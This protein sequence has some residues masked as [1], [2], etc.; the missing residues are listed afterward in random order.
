[1][2]E[3]A[4]ALISFPRMLQLI[5][6]LQTHEKRERRHE[7]GYGWDEKKG[8]KR[9]GEGRMLVGLFPETYHFESGN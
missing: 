2:L 4:V 7:N 6:L 1:M 3:R 9:R 8:Q 5:D